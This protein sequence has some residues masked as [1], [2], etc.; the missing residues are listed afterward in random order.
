MAPIHQ[1]PEY[2]LLRTLADAEVAVHYQKLNYKALIDAHNSE[3]VAYDLSKDYVH[4]TNAG[5]E[6][7]AELEDS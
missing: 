3:Y 6:R 2:R 4:I 5:R 1:T 7:L